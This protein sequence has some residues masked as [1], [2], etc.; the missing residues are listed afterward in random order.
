VSLKRVEKI[1]KRRMAKFL[2]WCEKQ[3]EIKKKRIFNKRFS[4]AERKNLGLKEPDVLLNGV[5]DSI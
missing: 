3:K 2:Q 5:N 1:G 4:Y